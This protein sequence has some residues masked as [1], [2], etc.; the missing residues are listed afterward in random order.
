MQVNDQRRGPAKRERQALCHPIRDLDD[1]ERNAEPA[2]LHAT[3]ERVP[4]PRRRLL[5]AGVVERS[6]RELAPSMDVDA[7]R[8]AVAVG[9]SW[10]AREDVH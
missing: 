5:E 6:K 7:G 4:K 2:H 9:L 1:V 8:H 10:K 3:R